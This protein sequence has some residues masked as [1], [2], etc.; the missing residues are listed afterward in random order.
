MLMGF[1]SRST[2]NLQEVWRKRPDQSWESFP[3]FWRG[4]VKPQMNTEVGGQKPE[5]RPPTSDC[6]PLVHLCFICVNLWLIHQQPEELLRRHRPDR[7]RQRQHG[8]VAGIRLLRRP[9]DR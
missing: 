9:E 4:S 2:K 6:R 3:V 7:D 8:A 5:V 1:G